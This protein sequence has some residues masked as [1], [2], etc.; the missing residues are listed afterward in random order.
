[1][2]GLKDSITFNCIVAIDLGKFN[3]VVCLYDPATTAHELAMTSINQ[4]RCGSNARCSE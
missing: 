3:S 4:I 1:M 2:H